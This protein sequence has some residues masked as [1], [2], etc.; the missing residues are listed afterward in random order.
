MAQQRLENQMMVRVI[1]DNELRA[2]LMT[3]RGATQRRILRPGI[4]ASLSPILKEA[5]RLAPKRSGALRKAL[6]S[7]VHVNHR[8]G[9]IVG[10][11]GVRHN[12]E[13]NGKIANI[14]AQRVEFGWNHRSKARRGKKKY[15][16]F[17]L[18]DA[19]KI[20][21]GSHGRAAQPFLRPALKNK[22]AEAVRIIGAKAA[23]A[24][25]REAA[26]ASAKGRALR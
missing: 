7:K 2:T 3:L 19:A 13:T 11:V 8:T 17:K 14:Y 4:K 15:P 6:A 26:K 22:R 1:G 18:S 24:L 25:A 23:V 21:V 16:K 20:E 9:Q 10:M 5:R 12:V